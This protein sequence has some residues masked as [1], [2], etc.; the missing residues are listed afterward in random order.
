MLSD[1]VHRADANA[2][3]GA[4]NLNSFVRPVFWI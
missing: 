4:S 3:K 2:F 1:L